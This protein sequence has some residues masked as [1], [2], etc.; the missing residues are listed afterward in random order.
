MSRKIY[1]GFRGKH[2]IAEMNLNVLPADYLMRNQ[3]SEPER[4]E[5]IK[6]QAE[7]RRQ[8]RNIKRLSSKGIQKCMTLAATNRRLTIKRLSV[9]ALSMARN[10]LQKASSKTQTSG[11]R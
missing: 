11:T 4:V 5:K 3:P 9:A 8:Q 10:Y 1:A 6:A 2:P 7:H